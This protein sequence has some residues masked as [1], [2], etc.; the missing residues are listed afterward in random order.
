MFIVDNNLALGLFANRQRAG[1]GNT[2]GSFNDRFI[3]LDR[4]KTARKIRSVEGRIKSDG[5]LFV[6]RVGGDKNDQ[7]GFGKEKG[8]KK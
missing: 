5:N 2:T 1:G 7:L 3:F 4:D 6:K 8:E